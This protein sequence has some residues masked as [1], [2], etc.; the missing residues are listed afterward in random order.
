MKNNILTVIVALI[1][2]LSCNNAEKKVILTSATTKLE[3]IN[4]ADRYYFT[5]NFKKSI[6]LFDKI[7]LLDSTLGEIYYKRGYCKAQLFDY[8]G[9]SK[10]FLKAFSLQFRM[11]E[12]LFNLGCN[13][14][15][16]G[17]DTLALKYFSKA[18]EL[19]PKNSSAM[20]E[21]NNIKNR[22][23]IVEL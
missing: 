22:L 4:E 1:V 14:A 7:E 8:D 18:Y 9:S 23:G 2:L 21:M 17:N 3:L 13:S 12:S 6:E 5:N 10:D 20:K 16:I 15:V 11:D 19:N